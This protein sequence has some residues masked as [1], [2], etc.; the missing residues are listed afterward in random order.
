MSMVSQLVK[1]CPV[2]MGT[3]CSLLSEVSVPEHCKE[4]VIT[5]STLLSLHHMYL[6]NI[7][8]NTIS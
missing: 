4:I 6:G 5:L 1:K 8:N 2:F 7:Y 3:K